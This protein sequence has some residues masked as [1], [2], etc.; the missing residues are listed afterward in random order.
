MTYVLVTLIGLFAFAFPFWWPHQ[1]LVN[2]A[3]AYDAPLWAA[4]IAGLC[5]AAI[6]IDVQRNQISGTS[7]AILG[8]LAACVGLLR[9]ID[10]PAGG[11]GMFFLLIIAGAALGP[12]TGFLLGIFGMLISAFFTGGLG[13]WLPFQMLA[14]GWMGGTSGLLANATR[15]APRYIRIGSLVVFAWLWGFFY[16]AITDL[17]F[18]PLTI[19]RGPLAWSP[20]ASTV[21]NLHHFWSFYVTTSVVWD[22]AG[23]FAN[24]ALVALIAPTLLLSFSRV[25][26][27][28]NPSVS[29]S[30][31]TLTSNAED[32]LG[33]NHEL[34]SRFSSR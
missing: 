13:P 18:W 10:L 2:Q 5:V 12:R 6:A 9:A 19:A 11:N 1:Q 16:G 29:W 21:T 30:H 32:A 26:S 34:R 20:H 24:A 25:R 28:M 7:V 14:A 3:H 23:A 27:R 22:A 17:W 4:V 8:V 15:R 33:L 31:S